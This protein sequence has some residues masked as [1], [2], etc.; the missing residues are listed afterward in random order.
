MSP[1]EITYFNAT[2]NVDVINATHDVNRMLRGKPIKEGLAVI[3]VPDSGASVTV[4]EPLPQ[5]IEQLKES[6]AVFPGADAETKNRKK[7]SVKIAPRVR[8]SLL[9]RSITIPIKDGKLMMGMKESIVV[10]DFDSMAR[11]RQIVIQIVAS[12][13]DKKQAQPGRRPPARRG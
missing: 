13:D 7:E 8:A 9:G 10:V 5:V 2:A 3:M 6:F 1:I 11:R 4:I 12:A